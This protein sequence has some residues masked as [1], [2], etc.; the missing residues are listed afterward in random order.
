[1]KVTGSFGQKVV[2]IGVLSGS[3]TGSLFGTASW[4][5]NA[6]T[7]SYALNAGTGN[8]SGS[9]YYVAVFSGSDS[10]VTGSIYDSGSFTAIGA[11][12]TPHLDAPER[13]FVDASDTESYNLISGHGSIN[14]YLQLNIKNFSSGATGSSDIVATA[15]NGDESSFFIDMGVNSSGYNIPDGIGQAN[16][17]Y[18]YSTAQDLLIGNASA[19]KRVIIFNGSG[20]ALDNARIYITPEGTVGI[21]A[22][23]TNIANPEALLV[24]P[25]ASGSGLPTDFSNLIVGRGTVNE[26]YLQLNMINLGTGSYASTD[27]VAS[28]DLG[29]ETTNYIDMGINAS[30]HIVDSTFAPGGANDSYLLSTA[31]D[32]LIGSA[33]SGE[34]IIW[35]GPDFDDKAN[36]KLI[37]KPNDSHILTGSLEA[38]QG[39]TGSLYG[40]ASWAL[41]TVTSS[42]VLG[43]QNN[44]VA[45]WSGS[46]N[47]TSSIIYQNGSLLGINNPTPNRTLDLISLQSGSYVTVASF[48]APNNNIVGNTTQFY[49]GAQQAPGNSISWTF[50]YQ[51]NN[52]AANRM[53]FE[54][55]GYATPVLS[56]FR[57]GN[58]VFGGAID[59]GFKHDVQG[60]GR[61]TNNLI[62][63]GSVTATTGFTGS[64]F[65]TASWAQNFLTSSV[66][67]ASYAATASSADDFVVRNSLTASNA[68]IN[69]TIT[70]Q[71]LVVQT[72]TSS[73]VYSS[74]SNNFG[75]QLTDQQTFTGSVNI[76]GSLTVN[77]NTAITSDVT[78]SMSVA[79]ASYAQT[80]SYALATANVFPYTGSAIITGSLTVTGSVNV[81]G[82]TTS[83][84]IISTDYTYTNWDGADGLYSDKQQIFRNYFGNTFGRIQFN[85][86]INAFGVVTVGLILAGWNNN[87]NA[88]HVIRD[89][90]AGNNYIY[91]GSTTTN[92]NKS[93][94]F[95]VDTPGK[96]ILLPRMGTA[97]YINM[98]APPQGL[99]LYDTGSSTEGFYYY[100][101]GSIKSW[102]R[103]LNSTGSQ[104]I[105]GSLTV[106]EGITG[107][108]FGTASWAQNSITASYALNVSGTIANAVSASYAFTA[109]S[110]ISSSF[111]ISASYV[112]A[113]G[114]V[115]LNLSQI[116]TG[117]VT[118]SVNTST[119][120][121]S[122]VSSSNTLMVI[123]KTGSLGIN[124]ANP[125]SPIN[126][127]QLTTG[128]SGITITGY[129]YTGPT[130]A[131]GV[132]IFMMYNDTDNRQLAFGSTDAIGS[133][134]VGVF[135]F[136]TGIAGYANIDAVS[137]NGLNRL[138]T[139]IGTDTSNVGIG[140]NNGT[141]YSITASYTGKLNIFTT[142]ADSSTNLLIK[143]TQS[144]TGL[145]VD[146]RNSTDNKILQLTNAGRL[147]IGD[148]SE[149]IH[150]LD[151]SGSGRFSE[152][153][154]VTGSLIAPSI[155]GS[156]FGTAS[157]AQNSITASYALNVSGT[158][159]NAISASYAYTASSAI[160]ASQAQ[161]ASYVL[162]AIS[163][164]YAFT[165]SSAVNST[166]T[167]TASSA[168]DFVV[169]NS[170]TAS[171]ALITGTIT[172]QT[173]VVQTVTSSIVYS[174]GSNIF[175]S[176]LT[177]TQVFTGSVSITGSLS[178]NGS[179][180]V[181]SNQTGSMSV[182]SASFAETASYAPNIYNSN[183]VLTG[184]R[185]IDS[186][187]GYELVLN[188]KVGFSNG[189]MVSASTGNVGT[190]I[191][192]QGYSTI[193]TQLYFYPNSGTN[194]AQ[195][196]NIIPKGSGFNSVFKSQF[197]VY[198]T[199]AIADPA[200]VEFVTF[201]AAGNL[202]TFASGKFGTGTIRPLMFSAGYATD[203]ST[204][205]NQLYLA[206]SSN[207]IIGASDDKGFKFDVRGTGRYT[208]DLTVTGSV[209]AT[210]G[211]TGSLFGTASWAQNAISSSYVLNAISS[212]FS[213]T[214]SLPLRGVVTA[215]ALNTTIT[216]T[217]GDNTT[218][219]VTVS[220]SGSV[221]SAS[222]AEYAVSSSNAL[223]ASYV[224]NA[225]SASYAFTASSALSASQAQTASY[226]NP[227]NQTV[228]ITG[229][230]IVSA[231]AGA[232]Y[233]LIVQNSDANIL[234]TL[235]VSGLGFIRQYNTQTNFLGGSIAIGKQTAASSGYILEVTGSSVMTGSLTVTQGITGSLFGTASWAENA[236]TSSY[237]LNA[238]SSSYAF[239][240]SSAVSSSYA[241]TASYVANA[242]SFPFTGS[243]VITGSLT[244]TGSTSVESLNIGSSKFNNTSS[245]TSAGT[246]IVS[247]LP[248][249]SY[250]SCFYNYTIAS[251][252][253]ARSGQ[254]M[255][256]W[257]GAN[258][259]Y[260]EVTT[261]DIGN[262]ATASFAVA[263][264]GENIQLSFSAPGSWT[265]KNIS[266][267]L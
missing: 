153:L 54:F 52:S 188:P 241:L 122:L 19:G 218:F 152:G 65:G 72:V 60:T 250:T 23:D 90:D 127:N 244:V 139:I 94:S 85:G 15:D 84:V 58:S 133:S 8:V 103:L 61:Y 13:L 6:I 239:T 67:S 219:D 111:A 129:G 29:T 222:Y 3:F 57:N 142:S 156:L 1:M 200:N 5:I 204:N 125:I 107:S 83:K 114:V 191:N 173:L 258:I 154:L 171:N 16:D 206:T 22:S 192:T 117:S 18:L 26:S 178:V 229:S 182:L 141:G 209:T 199:D 162:N 14:N 123:D 248:T 46:T 17:A 33:T 75:S 181:L 131:Q 180:V 186:G 40:T 9:Q 213:A 27:I 109:S 170:I 145:Y 124:T 158:I 256:V 161:T 232:T 73:I 118:A 30:T 220:Q 38:T 227:L 215:S 91:I 174:S 115:G 146:V 74:G 92:A 172:A 264:S 56:M 45:L 150:R 194:V 4:A 88:L 102:T 201:R 110:A 50:N 108:L 221:S 104:N 47:L 137:G 12:T 249:S 226:V 160:S 41:N 254:V 140:N 71:T 51:G 119:T 59:N 247:V 231:S 48:I 266:N 44:Y 144:A 233:G 25:L 169:R 28:N 207:V 39:F 76:T 205:I 257:N 261:M 242:S 120:A 97:Q 210:T 128:Q 106:T 68:L 184:N 176:Q 243:A 159:D 53:G 230:L 101:S 155:T 32:L 259:R 24:E 168:D 165:A 105:S 93:A 216:F 198:N 214:S 49:L 135:R 202:F 149:S 10:V 78:A 235:T 79:S 208:N 223:T 190:L 246:T 89:Q 64:L 86:G 34:V 236:L 134:T 185:T 116:S 121:F 234:G 37:L 126:I 164:S 77:G 95:Q 240:A 217:R 237:I 157:W 36:A 2:A 63:T 132:S 138:L 98:S 148:I 197:S 245:I 7:A 267:L 265:V 11:T 99:F 62:V 228:Q 35:T 262:T 143:K 251:G 238:V 31:N 70:A 130:S 179:S 113:S 175:G 252:S 43:G 112:P 20:P 163:S 81:S 253:N 82:S 80:A 212:S 187:S 260:T 183:G 196:L 166:N 66:T 177:D 151:V 147:I 55:N 193:S 96:G 224:L 100:S 225:V 263:L 211:F 167:L 136:Q 195:T 69:G 87:T 203:S 255:S 21:N 189:F 42:N